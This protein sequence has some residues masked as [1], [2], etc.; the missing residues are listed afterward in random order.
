MKVHLQNAETLNSTG[1]KKITLEITAK[2]DK[3]ALRIL[4]NLEY[5]KEPQEI[6]ELQLISTYG[7]PGRSASKPW[8]LVVMDEAM[9]KDLV[10]EAPQ[11]DLEFAQEVVEGLES[12]ATTDNSTVLQEND[13]PE[14]QEASLQV[15]GIVSLPEPKKISTVQEI[16]TEL[17]KTIIDTF[18]FKPD[19]NIESED[20]LKQSWGA[21][22]LDLTNLSMAIEEK[23]GVTVDQD[24]LAKL[25]VQQISN[26]IWQ[27]LIEKRDHNIQ[28]TKEAEEEKN[29]PNSL[30]SVEKKVFKIIN[31]LGYNDGSKITSPSKWLSD[32][33]INMDALSKAISAEFDRDITFD[34]DIVVGDVIALT[35]AEVKEG[36]SKSQYQKDNS[37]YT[38]NFQKTFDYVKNIINLSGGINKDEIKLDS[39]ITDDL[40]VDSLDAANIALALEKEFKICG[41]SVDVDEVQGRTVRDLV[42]YVNSNVSYEK[43][44]KS[45]EPTINDAKLK[46]LKIIA[47]VM[48]AD[49]DNEVEMSDNLMSDYDHEKDELANISDLIYKEFNVKLENQ[50]FEKLILSEIFAKILA[51]TPQKYII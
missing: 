45:S 10:R 2:D 7:L 48:Q 36:S 40:G 24:D 50:D 20:H 51:K 3:D 23:F 29:N 11:I 30:K 28:A 46:L 42:N 49:A 41:L 27:G 4:R 43:E 33:S 14:E 44:T 35:Y 19:T 34:K 1:N 22:S 9:K 32:L 6:D 18:D 47:L 17:K 38:Q 16:N 12:A 8:V 37:I 5:L 31:L 21:D 13:K 26:K 39:L 25:Q 15:P